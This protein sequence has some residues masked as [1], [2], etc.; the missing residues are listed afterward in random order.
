MTTTKAKAPK[1]PCSAVD[2]SNLCLSSSF[3]FC[4]AHYKRLRELA[5]APG[6]TLSLRWPFKKDSPEW[7]AQ[8]RKCVA[9]LASDEGKQYDEE[10]LT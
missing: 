5:A 7:I 2:C 4:P 10:P 9:A 3:Y 6:S 1:P 8:V